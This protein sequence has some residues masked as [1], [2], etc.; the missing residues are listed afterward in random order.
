MQRLGIYWANKFIIF[1]D[2]CLAQM[3]EGVSLDLMV[4]NCKYKNQIFNS[5]LTMVSNIYKISFP[6]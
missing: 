1:I 5:N 3:S 4:A 6:Y 2:N